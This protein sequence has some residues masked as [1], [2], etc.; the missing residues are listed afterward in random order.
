MA[1]KAETSS[2]R[3]KK[4]YLSQSDVPS[5]GITE[6]LRIAETL[7]DNYGYN[8]T[9]PLLV[10]KSL[11]MQPSSSRFRMLSGASVAY[12][13]TDGAAQSSEIS[14]TELGSRI[15]KPL[16]EGDDA[17][18]KREAFLKPRVIGDFLRK[19]DT[20]S[21]P[22]EDIGKNVLMDMGVPDDKTDKVWN[23]ILED[24][25]ALGL[26]EVIKN[27]SYVH[28]AG[29][30]ETQTTD[31]E[32]STPDDVDDPEKKNLPEPETPQPETI[33][34]TGTSLRVFI[35]HGKNM[36]IVKQVETMLGMADL[37]YEVAVADETTAIPVSEKVFSAMRNCNAA[38]IVVSVEENT[39]DGA[40][41]Y[42]INENVL[43]E[44][45]A[46]FVLYDR[47]VVLVWDK[48]LTVPSNLQGLYRCEFQGDELSWKAAMKLMNAI[49][50]FRK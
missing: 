35:S 36:E 42:A 22:R 11:D 21:I 33:G 50:E 9:T 27:K 25:S 4:R 8:S 40:D 47:K 15:V 5:V 49:K 3:L 34:I 14:L 32:L 7:K 1:K 41:G 38:V 29:V 26:I 10:A 12:G 24:A 17:L 46:A 20:A 45:G 31:D 39:A 19:Y 48:R 23:L 44:I 28:L 37:E 43:I 16:K 13:V 2:T 18:A 6:A 30:K